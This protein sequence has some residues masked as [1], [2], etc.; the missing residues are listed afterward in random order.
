MSFI[1]VVNKLVVFQLSVT[2]YQFKIFRYQGIE[3]NSFG[4]LGLAVDL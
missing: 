4:T 2:R 3:I 1:D